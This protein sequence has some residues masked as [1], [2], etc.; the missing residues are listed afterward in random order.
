MCVN[1]TP[2]RKDQIAAKFDA[3]DQTG[4][5]WRPETWQDYT[6]PFITHDALKRRQTLAGAYSMVPK[7]KIAPGMKRYST[8]NARA[9]TIGELRSYAKPW[10]EGLRCLVPLQNFFEPNYES[11]QAERW[12]IGML[13]ETDFA[14]AGLYRAWEEDNG[15]QS[16]SFTQITI[17][18]DE[19]P[20]MKRFHKPGDEKRSLVVIAKE[21]FD[22]W[23]SCS[24]LE[25]A[26]AFLQLPDAE[27]MWAKPVP[28][29]PKQPKQKTPMI[30]ARPKSEIQAALPIQASLL[31]WD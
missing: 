11:G 13:D 2:T 8:M 4:I 1:Y 26:R 20:L 7:H 25:L 22:D 15:Q 24:K 28:V 30:K 27:R 18:A 5:D 23:L 17:N 14:V 10:R 31:D 6:A 19:H 9:E 3:I 16:F 12:Q 21:D 29:A